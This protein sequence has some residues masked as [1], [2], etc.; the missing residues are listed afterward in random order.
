MCVNK[1]ILKLMTTANQLTDMEFDEIS[2]VTRPA[3]QLSKVVLFKSDT[4]GES[5]SNEQEILDSESHDLDSLN[6]AEY[7]KGKMELD[8]EEEEEEEMGKQVRKEDNVN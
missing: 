3:N 1:P 8:D 6:K 7:E 5:M 2:L 4:D